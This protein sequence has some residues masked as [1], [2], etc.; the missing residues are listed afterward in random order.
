MTLKKPFS[1]L[2]IKPNTKSQ[3]NIDLRKLQEETILNLQNSKADNTVRAYKS[4]F[5]DF[6]LFCVQNGFSPL[7]TEPKTVSLTS[8]SNKPDKDFS[9]CSSAS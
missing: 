4:D 5:N 8:G 6:S 3:I 1:M 2:Q 9:T 7:P